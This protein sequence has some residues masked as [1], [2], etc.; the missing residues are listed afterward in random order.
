MKKLW[1]YQRDF[2]PAALEREAD[3]GFNHGRTNYPVDL[4]DKYDQD[5]LKSAAWRVVEE[6]SEVRQALNE[7]DFEKAREEVIDV[8]CFTMNISLMSSCLELSYPCPK[9]SFGDFFK[10]LDHLGLAMNH[11][12]NRAWCSSYRPTNRREY[13]HHIDLFVS[14]MFSAALSLMTEDEIISNYERKRQINLSRVEGGY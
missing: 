10:G 4:D 14:H 7:E 13:H 1:D 9:G 11:L 2:L 6:L 12:K 5:R 8:L 3:N